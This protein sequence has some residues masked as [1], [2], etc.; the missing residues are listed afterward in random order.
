MHVWK[1][2]GL[3]AGISLE[4]IGSHTLS[5]IYEAYQGFMERVML[6]AKPMI[7]YQISQIS[8]DAFKNRQGGDS[9]YNR[10]RQKLTNSLLMQ[11]AP[12]YKKLELIEELQGARSNITDGRQPL[13]TMSPA[14]ARGIL[15]AIKDRTLWGSWNTFSRYYGEIILTSKKRG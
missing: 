7:D 15:S 6:Q 9:P 1:V 8:D 4:T 11:Y 2:K 12:D 13:P 14:T 10:E 5:Q 3:A